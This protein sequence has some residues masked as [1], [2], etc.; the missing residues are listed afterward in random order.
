MSVMD[1][2]I[3]YYVTVEG[4]EC[5]LKALETSHLKANRQFAQQVFPILHSARQAHRNFHAGLL[6]LKQISSPNKA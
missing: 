2:E 4:A 5:G 6:G 3:W 1:L